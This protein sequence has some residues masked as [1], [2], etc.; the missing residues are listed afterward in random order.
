MRRIYESDALSR[1]D[2]KSFTPGERDDDPKPQAFRSIN[3]SVWSD[4]FI[5][6][7]IRR[8][9]VSV[10][11]KT[12]K[13]TFDREEGIPFR[14]VVKNHLPMPVSLNT[15]SPILWNWSVDGHNRATQ[16]T[17][18]EIPEEQSKFK[19]DRGETI[20]FQ[21]TWDQMF[22]IDEREWE[23]AGPGEH[24]LRAGI[25]LNTTGDHNLNDELTVTVNP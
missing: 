16:V 23:P 5:P 18:R 20:R 15:A 25:N 22:R 21:K 17:I 13:S 11:L 4:H 1:D 19:L 14:F 3:A 6:H 10:S 2:E 12:P 8:W 24:T 9:A 7:R